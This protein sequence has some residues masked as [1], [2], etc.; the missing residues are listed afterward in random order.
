MRD[1]WASLVEIED[2]YEKMEELI[3]TAEE[4][5]AEYGEKLRER[6]VKEI[7]NFWE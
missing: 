2:G 7:K 4:K 1:A 3:E 5:C 6:L